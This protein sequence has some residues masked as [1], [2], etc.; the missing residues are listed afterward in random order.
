MAWIVEYQDVLE[1]LGSDGL[2]C[3]YHNSGAFGFNDSVSTFSRGWAGEADASIRPEAQA[4]LRTVPPPF[5]PTLAKQ[6][7]RAWQA[8]LPGP[9]WVMP[10][11]HWAY[12]L[13]F[14]S[15]DW[16][17]SLLENSGVDPGLLTGRNNAA[18]LEF[19]LAEAEWCSHLVE[20][21]LRMLLGSDFT[22]AW[23]GR[24]TICTVHH[25]KQL[26]WTSSNPAL[27]ENLDR[28]FFV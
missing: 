5:E 7:V 22:L 20:G 28:A 23:P 8:F 13:E 16:I 14:G 26:W 27:I 18:A 4:L 3:L 25:H 11:S 10:K 21:L 19:P 12:E 15:K 24:G 2:R 1:R 17:A 9:I 6:M